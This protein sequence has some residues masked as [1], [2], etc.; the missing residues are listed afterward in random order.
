[1]KNILA[2]LIIWSLPIWVG[3]HVGEYDGGSGHH[4]MDWMGWGMLGA[5][6]FWG[7]L[8]TLILLVWLIVGVLLVIWLIKQI[9][10]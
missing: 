1:M 5:G 7:L 9:N 3:A 4:M 6:G 8:V 10:K 2:G